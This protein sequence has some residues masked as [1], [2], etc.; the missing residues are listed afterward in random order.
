MP[1]QLAQHRNS[2]V[3]EAAL[4]HQIPTVAHSPEMFQFE[5]LHNSYRNELMFQRW[6][7]SSYKKPCQ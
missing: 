1:A 6:F 5:G 3:A 7:R 4:V 2:L